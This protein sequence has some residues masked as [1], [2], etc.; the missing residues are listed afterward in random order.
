MAR[1]IYS[2]LG[3]WPEAELASALAALQRL[4]AAIDRGAPNR[5]LPPSAV[6]A[7]RAIRDFEARVGE[8]CGLR[9]EIVQ[10]PQGPAIELGNS[11]HRAFPEHESAAAEVARSLVLVL[12]AFGATAAF[13][14]TMD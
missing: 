3:R 9:A 10:T 5:E 1:G 8:R 11:D 4:C 2:A 13:W 14:F 12:E 7:V 6:A